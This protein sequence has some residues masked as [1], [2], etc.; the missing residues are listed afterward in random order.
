MGI[1]NR[2]MQLPPP[3][4][5]PPGIF[6]CAAPGFFKGLLK[7]AGLMNITEKEMTGKLRCGTPDTFWHF[8]NE[9]SAP[10]VAAMKKTDHA[11]RASIKT[12]TYALLEKNF[13]GETAIDYGALVVCGRK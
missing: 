2:T 7:E 6:R 11:T 8:H 1:I 12:E 5:H 13:P 3:P 10:I 4:P 9:V